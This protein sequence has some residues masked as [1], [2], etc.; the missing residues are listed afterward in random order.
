MLHIGIA[1]EGGTTAYFD[2]LVDTGATTTCIS[3]RVV[4]ALALVPIGMC[5]MLTAGETLACPIY[6][7]DVIIPFGDTDFALTDV[8]LLEFNAPKDL[9][10]LLGRDILCRGHLSLS[11]D[12]HLAFS[13]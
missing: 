6:L 11:F 1:Q 7:A 4:E 12:G 5:D 3:R 9:D 13:L 10:I 2:A 8:K